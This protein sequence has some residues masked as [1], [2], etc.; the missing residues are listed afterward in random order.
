MLLVP[1]V[2][3]AKE[4]VCLNKNKMTLV[5]GQKK[6]L[7]VK[8]TTKKAKWT[9]SKKRVA[10][11]N[12]IGEV[13]AKKSG[14]TVITAT[15]GTKK[16]TCTVKVKEKPS[17][18]KSQIICVGKKLQLKVEGTAKNIKWRSSDK[19]IV[20]VNSNGKITGVKKGT[21]TITATVGGK[22]LKCKVKVKDA[23]QKIDNTVVV[24]ASKSVFVTY[25]SD[26][27]SF[28]T[29]DPSVATVELGETGWD[30][31]TKGNEA[32]LIIYGHKKGSAVI[33]VKNNCNDKKMKIKV[34]VR[35]KTPLTPY[36]KLV[37]Y[38]INKGKT[39]GDGNRYISKKYNGNKVEARIIYDYWEKELDFEYMEKYSDIQV[40][41]LIL[42][43]DTPKNC[44]VVMWISSPE[45]KE[46]QYVT[47]KINILSYK[48]ETL[49]YEEAW[50]GTTADEKLQIIANTVTKN[51]F[52]Y[53]GSTLNSCVNATLKEI[54]Q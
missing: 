7:K 46:E 19:K 47:A 30:D 38:L 45:Y 26:K 48:G 23:V 29:S 42:G 16:Y 9:S 14:T 3:Y 51:A 34:Q 50:Y 24:E 15:V 32:E 52:K 21:A 39:D 49:V 33:T 13:T 8:N 41:W 44:Y 40:K 20:K 4:K 18:E 12:A 17:L 37:E 10:E 5:V 36:E 2:S 25:Y 1:T 43:A 31:E 27:I 11:V 54:L 35:K 6:T 53:I 22:K 28:E